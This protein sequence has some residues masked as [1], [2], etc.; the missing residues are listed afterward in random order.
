[1]KVTSTNSPIFSSKQYFLSKTSYANMQKLLTKMNEQTVYTNPNPKTFESKILS[2]VYIDNKGYF[3][4][5]RWLPQKNYLPTVLL[6]GN[7]YIQMNNLEIK[8]NNCDG[9][10]EILKK[11]WYKTAKSVVK[12]AEKYIKTGLKEFSNENIV[13]KHFSIIQGFT[14][15]GLKSLKL[16]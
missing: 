7:S 11:P 4:D 12:K 9:Q 6:Q 8:I 5:G 10:I 3:M 13:E 16:C 14:K 15:E 1:M 2:R